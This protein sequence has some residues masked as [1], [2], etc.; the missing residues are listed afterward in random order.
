M[1]ELVA[2]VSAIAWPGA[3]IWIAYLFRGEIRGL[4]SRVSHLKYKDMEATFEKKLQEAEAKAGAIT[5]QKQAALPGPQMLSRLEQLQR[6]ADVSPRAA[7]MEAWILIESAA[8]QSGFVQG[9]SHP[10]VNPMLFV[11]SLVRDGKLPTDSIKLV[12]TLRDLRNKAAHL[13]EFS[14]TR[15]EADRYL[16]LAVQISTQIVDPGW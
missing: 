15:D 16:R 7:I 10:R 12:Q 14:V 2:I 11:D 13:P 1:S 4:A 6:I 8:G 5:N 3:A 9:A